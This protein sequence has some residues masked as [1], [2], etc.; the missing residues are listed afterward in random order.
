MPNFPGVRRTPIGGYAIRITPGAPW[1]FPAVMAEI[2]ENLRRERLLRLSREA[3]QIVGRMMAMG[4]LGAD[5]MPDG[6][7]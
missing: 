2:A 3:P 5:D 6:S 4:E 7:E 1:L